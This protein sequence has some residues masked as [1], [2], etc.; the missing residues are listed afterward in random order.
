VKLKV[1]I[2]SS[3]DTFG[4]YEFLYRMAKFMESDY[5]IAMVVRDRR[6]ADPWIKQIR[7]K[8]VKKQFWKRVFDF[9]KRRLGIKINQISTIP[10][11]VFL[12]GDNEQITAVNADQLLSLISFKPDIVISGMTDGLLNT[13]TLREIYDK[14]G[15]KVF[16]V[17]IDASFLTG[18]CHV[19]W[20]CQGFIDNCEV[21][22]AINDKIFSD[23]SQKNLSIK[24]HNIQRGNFELLVVPGWSK[25]QACKS[26]I[27]KDRIRIIPCSLVDTELFT[28]INRDIAKRI[29]G[30]PEYSKVIFAGSNNSKDLRKGRK[31]LAEALSNLYDNMSIDQRETIFILLSGN[32]NTEDPDTAKIKFPKKLVD[33]ISDYRLL[34]LAYQ[35]SSVFANPSLEDAGP[36]M[37]AEAL[38]CGTPVVG[39][40]TGI[41]FDETL[42]QDGK[43]GYRVK[44]GDSKALS[45]ALLKIISLDKN[46]FQSMSDAARAQAE[47]HTSKYAYLQSMQRILN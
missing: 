4:A 6:K 46:E 47:K 24:R 41:L 3:G 14:T 2:L 43:N 7:V 40:E 20:D 12:P 29:F 19:M 44:I 1:L 37:V 39:F 34:S 30:I 23:Y 36:M 33:F 28:N 18:G 26:S 38:A 17:M 45:H 31:F 15:A 11:Y 22:P 9:A 10:G 27:Y 13:S 35:A 8:T 25:H 21:C 32:H 16:Q 5:E 42:V